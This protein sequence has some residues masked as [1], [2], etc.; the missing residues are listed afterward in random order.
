VPAVRDAPSSRPAPPGRPILSVLT[1][2]HDPPPEM[3]AE[4]IES[5][6]NQTFGDW[7]FCLFDDGSSDRDV[8]AMLERYAASNPRIRLARR[9]HSGGIS[10][11]TNAALA[12]AS[13]EYIALLDH[14]DT[15]V[16]DAL[17]R[18]AAK[19][20]E[21][22]RVDMIYSDEEAVAD[23]RIVSRHRKPAWSPEL[24]AV[25][26]YTC[27]FGVYRRRL[28][29]ELG[30]FRSEFDG[31]QDYD[32]VLRLAERT[33]RIGHIPEIL[34]NWRAHVGSTAGG[35]Q[36]KPYAYMAQPRAIA[37]H[38]ERTGVDAEVQFGPLPGV[39]RVVHRMAPDV[40]VS[41]AVAVADDQGLA[42]AARSWTGQPHGSLDV[43]IAAPH[44][45]LETCVDALV[46]AGVDLAQ[47]SA[48]A[49]DP[50]A[51]RAA[52][53]AAAVDAARAEHLLLMQDPVAGL[54]HDWLARLIGYS[55]QEQ[56]GASGPTVLS[57]EG[58]IAE[59]GIA[60]PEGVPIPLLHGFPGSQGGPATM[61]VS[62]VSGVL[63]TSVRLYQSVG[64]L[65]ATC[66]DLVLVDYCRRALEAGLRIVTV[67]DV[68]MQATGPD[69]TTNDLPALWRLRETWLKAHDADPY[70]SPHYRTD[71]GDF[72][73]RVSLG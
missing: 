24:M 41:L 63:A 53:L 27:H 25:L 1:P 31:T 33:D 70:Y 55:A 46:G 39:H 58:R 13:G 3:L 42:E 57:P 30:G 59:A 54:T 34:Y 67:P 64:G 66:R 52:W 72:V 11:A 45:A 69:R 17:E 18:V 48:V 22:P 9:E 15:L 8:I 71:R 28:A 36:A 43:A 2:V 7:E 60:L 20:A 38:L 16:P 62:A 14:D 50:R 5:V 4:T 35:A 10:S 47:I 61:N 65:D 56:I 12:M 6:C 68:R 49:A 23:G 51:G 40:R 37:G 32:F 73:P 26:M 29:E 19:V 44:P 21:D